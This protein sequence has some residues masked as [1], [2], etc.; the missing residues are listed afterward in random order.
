MALHEISHSLLEGAES[1]VA[2]KAITEMDKTEIKKVAE[3]MNANTPSD[4]T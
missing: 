4:I 3:C 2:K 1:L